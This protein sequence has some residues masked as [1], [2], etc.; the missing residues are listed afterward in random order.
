MQKISQ[1]KLEKQAKGIARPC[2][3]EMRSQFLASINSKR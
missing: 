2:Q 1:A 3:E